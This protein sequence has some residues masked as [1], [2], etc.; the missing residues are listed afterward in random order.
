M[1]P[2]IPKCVIELLALMLPILKFSVE[3]LGLLLCILKLQ[4]PGGCLCIVKFRSHFKILGPGRVTRGK[5]DISRHGDPALGTCVPLACSS[6]TNND[7]G[8]GILL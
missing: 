3:W 5:F 4:I 1:A 6:D 8:W 7:P 2:F